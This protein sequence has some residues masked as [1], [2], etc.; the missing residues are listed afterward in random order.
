MDPV[1]FTGARTARSGRLL[2]GKKG[3][4]RAVRYLKRKGYRILDRNY[5]FKHWEIDIIAQKGDTIV[6]VEVKRRKNEEFAPVEEAIT[7]DKIKRV[8]RASQAYLL[9]KGLY[10]RRKIRYD[11]I[12]M[13]DERKEIIHYEGVWRNT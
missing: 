5:R 8:V 9:S 13:V 2:K 1:R 7:P 3:E 4:D 6:F 10:N 12:L 11:V